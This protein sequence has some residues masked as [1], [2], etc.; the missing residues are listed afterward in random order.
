MAEKLNIEGQ[1]IAIKTLENQDYI[2]LT[3]IAKQRNAE[4]PR[5]V[6]RA[7]LGNQDTEEFLELWESMYNPNFKRDHFAA[8]KNYFQRRK[9]NPQVKEYIS[10]TGAIGIVSTSG[11]YGGTFAHRDI[12]FEFASWISASF[13]LRIIVEFQRLRSEEAQRK[14]I[15]W[16]AGRELA[17]L[18]YPIQTA[19][20]QEVTG[21]L[22]EKKKG[23][24]YAENADMINKIV[25]GLT[26]KQWRVQNPDLKGNMRDYASTT[27]NTIIGNL[28]SF[29]SELIRKGASEEAREKALG[30]MAAFQEKILGQKY[31]P[32]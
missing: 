7:W 3:D 19:A 32:E 15:E 20:I 22:P 12:A 13:K 27:Q 28:E 17:R 23:G 2:S 21:S 16:N 5:D 6:I 25:F 26:A 29:N 14:R 1:E 30:E 18:N 24:V 4:R 8:F 11:R 9:S 10:E 31:L